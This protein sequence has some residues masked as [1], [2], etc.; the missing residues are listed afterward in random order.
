[1]Y[2]M[3][4]GML[5]G[6]GGAKL[7]KKPAGQGW[8]W[9][10][11]ATLQA[12][13]FKKEEVQGE[14]WFLGGQV[15]WDSLDW[16]GLKDFSC[17]RMGVEWA[18]AVQG[19][20]Q[21]GTQEN[22]Y[23]RPT[24]KGE[25]KVQG[26]MIDTVVSELMA[27]EST[28]GVLEMEWGVEARMR[29]SGLGKLVAQLHRAE[30]SG[31]QEKA[32]Q[33][34]KAGQAAIWR[35]KS[36]FMQEVMARVGKAEVKGEEEEFVPLTLSLARTDKTRGPMQLPQSHSKGKRRR[37]LAQLRKFGQV[38]MTGR[39]KGEG[40]RVGAGKAGVPACKSSHLSTWLVGKLERMLT[41]RELVAQ[42]KGRDD[43]PS[44]CGHCGE[45]A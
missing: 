39:D 22:G 21:R 17:G 6:R 16:A 32:V 40:P 27:Q 41:H 7:N 44:E 20:T 28:T 36:G 38:D 35:I 43:E 30:W 14:L 26:C 9:V 10:K 19:Y 29:M 25:A 13:R 12:A 4:K 11:L 31:A 15:A 37:K 1:M 45:V 2:V 18:E 5:K 23:R 24:A 42:W 33:L 8:A 3:P 34:M